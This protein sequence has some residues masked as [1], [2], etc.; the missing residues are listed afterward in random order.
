VEFE[1]NQEDFVV[2]LSNPV[3]ET[4]T[5]QYYTEDETAVS[6]GDGGDYEGI[7]EGQPLTLTFQPGETEKII[8][9]DTLDDL[10]YDPDE[11]FLVILDNVSGPAVIA[12]GEGVGT[13]LDND[14]PPPEEEEEPA[15]GAAGLEEECS[16]L[17]PSPLPA[18]KAM[19]EDRL[20]T[21][22]DGDGKV[23]PGDRL[24]YDIRITDI[25]PNKLNQL[26]Y[27]DPLSPH[28]EFVRGSLETSTGEG[29]LLT[30]NEREIVYV[31]FNRAQNGTTGK[32][33]F[34]LT[35]T[36][37][38]RVNSTIGNRVSSI[39]SQG[40]LYTGQSPTGVTDDP[41]T[42]RLDDPTLTRVEPTQKPD[43]KLP[44]SDDIKV[45][46]EI[47]GIIN[48]ASAQ[49]DGSCP[50][51]KPR[52]SKNKSG[53]R[54]RI[55]SPGS[56]VEFSV[57]VKNNTRNKLQGLQLNDLVD[58]HLEL[59]LDS[60]H[61]G[62]RP[63]EMKNTNEAG[64]INV[65]IPSIAPGDSVS[66]TY[67]TKVKSQIN[68]NVGYLGTN[69]FLTGRNI[70]THYSDDPTTELLSDR[71]VLLLPGQCNQSNYLDKWD[72][73]LKTLSNSRA[74]L[75]PAILSPGGSPQGVS[76]PG[77][78]GGGAET[79]TDNRGEPESERGDE[80]SWI[81]F[82]NDLEDFSVD[83]ADKL[84]AGGAGSEIESNQEPN[85]KDNDGLQPSIFKY[86]PRYVL[87]GA[88]ELSIEPG[89]GK[90]LAGLN[91]GSDLAAGGGGESDETDVSSR[92]VYIQ[93]RT[94]HPFYKRLE[95]GQLTNLGFSPETETLCEKEF[96]PY[97]LDMRLYQQ[98]KPGLS[99]SSLLKVIRLG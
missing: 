18:T 7:S 91:L 35:I 38:A 31:Q 62:G 3:S 50:D 5:V 22:K 64:L 41:D 88:G 17:C 74:A 77:I 39:A 40:T 79:G 72:R 24:Q 76:Y 67:L 61:L 20:I 13:I 78:A 83:L 57:T 98:L 51:C 47:T 99:G 58:Q 75:V 86:F 36:F 93:S 53:A 32:L 21:D 44:V 87:L 33:S 42:G 1:G 70:R 16:P 46:K 95:N 85:L 94:H 15:G 56:M 60:L 34:P 73:W 69:A 12:D 71:T 2:S 45:I 26:I 90:L 80:L 9:V 27:V 81:F 59:Q 25:Q 37:R 68:R 89:K 28:L 8:T 65:D 23:D 92:N 43:T 19:K 30:E 97:I 82:G 14:S 4:V 49:D 48:G 63:V 54:D 66:L 6:N 55:I 10:T 96:L 11:T 52:E 29:I 84:F